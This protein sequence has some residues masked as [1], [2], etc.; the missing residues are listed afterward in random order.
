MRRVEIAPGCQ[1]CVNICCAQLDHVQVHIVYVM[2]GVRACTGENP[3]AEQHNELANK[4]HYAL[5]SQLKEKFISARAT[6]KHPMAHRPRE[7]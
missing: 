7:R 6:H 5:L 3:T 4:S 2:V 1:Y